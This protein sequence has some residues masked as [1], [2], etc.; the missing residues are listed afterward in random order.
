MNGQTFSD[1]FINRRI[2]CLTPN[3]VI[4]AAG[5]AYLCAPR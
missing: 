1:R 5:D 4:V 2:V 3:F